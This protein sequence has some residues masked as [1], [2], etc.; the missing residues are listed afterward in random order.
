[1]KRFVSD[2]VVLRSR[3]MAL[4]LVRW[5]PLHQHLPLATMALLIAEV[6]ERP[7]PIRAWVRVIGRGC[8]ARAEGAVSA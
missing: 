5:A 8:R 2:Y 7:M 3:M 4:V 1:M 6:A